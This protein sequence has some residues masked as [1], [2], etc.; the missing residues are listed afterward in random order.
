M[1]Q[2]EWSRALEHGRAR[3]SVHPAGRGCRGKI[4]PGC[5]PCTVDPPICLTRSGS[6]CRAVQHPLN[7]PANGHRP[8]PSQAREA[9]C[10]A[11]FALEASGLG[12]LGWQGQQ[13]QKS[14]QGERTG[15]LF[16]CN[17]LGRTVKV[18]SHWLCIAAPAS[19]G[20]AP[21]NYF[22]IRTA[23]FAWACAEYTTNSNYKIPHGSLKLLI[24]QSL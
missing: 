5:R 10:L 23:H 8:P 12:N 6:K 9:T 22:G 17:W 15:T 16:D 7:L 21:T 20:R 13:R 18:H 1:E 3:C 19:S 14:G 11:C 24:A 4:R 2:S